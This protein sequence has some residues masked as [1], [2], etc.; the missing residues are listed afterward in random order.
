MAG[1]PGLTLRVPAPPFRQDPVLADVTVVEPGG[2]RDPEQ[3]IAARAGRIARG[4][5][6]GAE[7]ALEEYRGHLVLPGLVD[8]HTHLPPHNALGLVPYFQLLTLAHGVTSTRD[9]G[10]AD[11]TA[12][13]AA[14]AVLDGGKLPAPRLFACGPFVG[15]EPTRW[16]NTLVVRTPAEAREAVELLAEQG[17]ACVKSYDG[18]DRATVHAL[19][20]AASGS[21]LP[22]M[23][24][25]PTEL[26]FED[27]RIP[28]T[29]HFFGVPPPASL[30]ADTI[31]ERNAAWEAVDGARLAEAVRLSQELGI[32]HTPTLVVSDGVLRYRDHAAARRDPQLDLVPRLYPDAV[33]NPI[34]GNPLFAGVDD[35]YLDRL[36]AAFEKKKELVGRLHE[37]GVSLRLGTDTQQPFSIPGAAL[38]REMRLFESCGIAPEE[39]WRLATAAAGEALGGNGLGTLRDGAPADLL[40]FERDPTTDLGALDSLQAVVSGGRLYRVDD[41]RSAVATCQRQFQRRLFDRVSVR[42]ARREMSKPLGRP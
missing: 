13:P 9:A 2:A 16:K 11:G 25:V 31:L 39:I 29:Q 1:I 27:A 18:L 7:A 22:V 8:M 24:H 41:L 4:G 38:H 28:D 14:R 40:I 37:A 17:V 20:D 10:D 32:A 42:A 3:T 15:G 6:P 19:L 30:G 23:G 33:W 26:S 34:G 35:P 36:A 21:G 12:L 5:E